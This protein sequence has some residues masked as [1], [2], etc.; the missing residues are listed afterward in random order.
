MRRRDSSRPQKQTSD[1]EHRYTLF[2]WFYDIEVMEYKTF[3]KSNQRDEED[4]RE[5][6]SMHVGARRG[7]QHLTSALDEE[8]LF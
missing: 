6:D 3:K 8:D 5:A 1:Y 7:T 4:G 2:H